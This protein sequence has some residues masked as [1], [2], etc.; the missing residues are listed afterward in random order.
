M[1]LAKDGVISGLLRISTLRELGRAET[2]TA[3]TA[4]GMLLS[5]GMSTRA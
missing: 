4:L 2:V 5:P 1:P 3:A